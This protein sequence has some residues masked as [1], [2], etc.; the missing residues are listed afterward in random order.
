MNLQQSAEAFHE[1][2]VTFFEPRYVSGDSW[3]YSWFRSIGWAGRFDGSAKG[4]AAS[5]FL[6]WGLPWGIGGW[7]TPRI[8]A[9]QSD[10]EWQI[11][12]DVSYSPSISRI[13]D[14][15]AA[16]GYDWNVKQSSSNG[17]VRGD[18]VSLETG[19]QVRIHEVWIRTGVR[20]SLDSGELRTF[21]LVAEVGFEPW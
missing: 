1:P 5:G 3:W 12:F 13:A 7:F 15:Y 20:A 18:H 8:A 9:L 4:P 19:V 14:W 2:W 11:S 10:G 21:R 16:V 6:P 17:D